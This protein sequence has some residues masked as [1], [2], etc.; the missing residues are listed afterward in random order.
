[1]EDWITTTQA[2]ELSGYNRDWLSRI[3]KQ[4]DAF[5]VRKVEGRYWID[6]ADFDRWVKERKTDT[7]GRSGP[8]K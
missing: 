1:M 8:R 6:R 2:A 5:R 3:C 4:G 7:N